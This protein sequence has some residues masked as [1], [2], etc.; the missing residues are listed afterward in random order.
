MNAALVSSEPSHRFNKRIESRVRAV[1]PRQSGSRRI[2]CNHP[3]CNNRA[4]RRSAWCWR[5]YA[6]RHVSCKFRKLREGLPGSHSFAPA[7]ISGQI[8]AAPKSF[9]NCRFGKIPKALAV[10]C[11][12][13]HHHNVWVVDNR[14]KK[15]NRSSWSQ[16]LI[17]PAADSHHSAATIRRDRHCYPELAKNT[18]RR[19]NGMAAT[20][21]PDDGVV[22]AW[23]AFCVQ[24]FLQNP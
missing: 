19:Q 3:R 1:F 16:S 18:R 4:C 7:K 2:L 22:L 5:W 24:R 12:G 11:N 21:P 15:V 6:G 14:D 17:S 9:P 23:G 10:A 20:F 13:N 8:T